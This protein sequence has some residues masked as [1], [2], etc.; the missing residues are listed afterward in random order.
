MRSL[1]PV[2]PSPTVLICLV[3]GDIGVKGND[4]IFVV[5]VHGD[6]RPETVVESGG[7][8]IVLP[9]GNSRICNES[10]S[11]EISATI[12]DPGSSSVSR[13]GVV[14]SDSKRGTSWTSGLSALS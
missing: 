11:M 2:L 3:P 8:D 5:N 7:S 13:S 14:S 10:T 12:G 1:M 4:C 9:E 6:T